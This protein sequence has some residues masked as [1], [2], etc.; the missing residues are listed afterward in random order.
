MREKTMPRQPALAA[1]AHS[2]LERFESV[3]RVIPRECV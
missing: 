1:T 3:P 2:G